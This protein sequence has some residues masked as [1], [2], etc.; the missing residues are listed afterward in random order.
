MVTAHD[1]AAMKPTALLVNAAR[2]EIIEP[3]ALEHAL[4]KGRPGRAAVD[5]YENEP[6]L[7]GDHPLLRLP[8][9]TCTPH[10]AWLEQNTY[11]LYLGEAFENAVAFAA[12]RPVKLVNPEV[13]GRT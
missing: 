4:R 9:A 7:G 8:N 13:L 6:V 1:L 10:T 3:D 11:E 2:A 5:V 12:G